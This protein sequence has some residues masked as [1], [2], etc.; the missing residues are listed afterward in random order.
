VC[1]Y[2]DYWVI[3]DT[4]STDETKELVNSF[5]RERGIPGELREFNFE[6]FSSSRNRAMELANKSAGQFDYLLL[7]DADMVLAVEDIDFRKTLQAPAYRVLQKSGGLSYWN[8]RLLKRNAPARYR[9]VTHEY[10]DRLPDE[11]AIRSVWFRDHADGANRLGKLER[12]IALLQKGIAEEP[13]NARY[14]F[15]LAQTYR[16]A[17]RFAVAAATYAARASMGGWE[18]EIWN[19]QLQEAR[20]RLALDDSAGFLAAAMKAYE[21]RPHRAE[22][23]YELAKFYRLHGAHDT[24]MHFCEAASSLS[25]PKQDNLFIEDYVYETGIREEISI[26]GFYSKMT[27]RQKAGRSMCFEL[28]LDRNAPEPSRSLAR[29]NQ[30]FYAR[31]GADVFPSLQT[32]SLGFEAPLGGNLMNPSVVVWN[33]VNYVIARN[34]NYHITDD[35]RYSITGGGAI[36]TRNYLLQMDSELR[37][38]EAWSE[39]GRPANM[40]APLYSEVRGFEDARLFVWRDTLWCST[41]VREL[42]SPGLCQMVLGRID[43]PLTESCALADWRVLSPSG[44]K[45]HQKNWMP[46]V[47]ADELRFVYSSDPFRIVDD[48]ARLINQVVP[49]FEVSHLRG[50]SQAI[51]FD[52]GWLMLAHEVT[53]LD[54]RRIYLHRFVWFDRSLMTQRVSEPFYFERLGIE[55]AAGLAQ[56]S[57]AKRLIVSFGVNDARALIGTL[58]ADKVR[59]ALGLPSQGLSQ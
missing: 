19:A 20:C 53:Q 54:E 49:H 29:H 57:D 45:N 27:T 48:Q 41:S 25:L 3:C 14:V 1:D 22:T 58:L 15:Y 12:D 28:A 7:M 38:V 52:N 8:T 2:I 55:F 37:R 18:E 43:S 9:G 44:P 11:T 5:F 51:A 36:E 40:P 24:A 32:G 34:V 13:G 6:D 42:N 59:D 10:L 56:H 47:D 4:G 16:D 35:G 33:D 30:I 46:L 31:P 17:G 39:I 50:G 23:L 21:R 26:S